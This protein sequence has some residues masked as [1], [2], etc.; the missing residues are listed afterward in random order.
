MRLNK[1]IAQHSALSRRA[2]DSVIEQGRVRVNDA[3]PTPGQNVTDDDIV[4]LDGQKLTIAPKVQTI[5]LNKPVGFV[6]SRQGQGSR[7]I[8]ELLPT[9]LHHLNPVG[10]LDKDSSGLLLLTNDGQLAQQ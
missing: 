10:R 1:F 3:Q 9:E 5:I 4:E 8:Y 7:T 2:A 6:V